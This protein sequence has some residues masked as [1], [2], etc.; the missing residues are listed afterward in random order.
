MAMTNIE[1][2]AKILEIKAFVLESKEKLE[3]F[4]DFGLAYFELYESIKQ[5]YAEIR[6]LEI[7]KRMFALID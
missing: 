7:L 3:L 5:A 4:D 6:R 1:I 2:D